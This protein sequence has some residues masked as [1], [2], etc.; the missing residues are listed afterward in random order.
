MS[1]TRLPAMGRAVQ[2]PTGCKAVALQKK[3]PKPPGSSN[4]TPVPEVRPTLSSISCSVV[5]QA[6]GG[7]YA[8][9]F[10]WSQFR[11]RMEK[12][13]QNMRIKFKHASGECL[14]LLAD[15]AHRGCVMSRAVSERQAVLMLGPQISPTVAVPTCSTKWQVST[16]SFRQTRRNLSTEQGNLGIYVS[17]STPAKLAAFLSMSLT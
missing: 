14:Y 13:H 5:L 17:S 2:L 9:L 16:S 10:S 4:Q 1:V 3:T 15:S 7:S 11:R 6:G 12:H 8:R